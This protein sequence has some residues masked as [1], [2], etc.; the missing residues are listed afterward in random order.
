[1]NFQ[2]EIMRIIS[3]F[4]YN[5]KILLIIIYLFL[6][7]VIVHTQVVEDTLYVF[8]DTVTFLDNQ[9]GLILDWMANFAV[10][11]NIPVE[12][13][14]IIIKKVA[15]VFY[16]LD[17]SSIFNTNFKISTGN[18]P[19]EFILYEQNINIDSAT[20]MFPEWHIYELDSAVQIVN[21][22]SNNSFFI[23]GLIFLRTAASYLT[24][25]AISNQYIFHAYNEN[26][27]EASHEYFPVKV[28]VDKIILGIQEDF[29]KTDDFY[30]YQN[31]P[32]PF[33]PITNIQFSLSS[34]Q[35]VTLRVYDVLGK[36]I[37][38]L[39]HE[40]K[41][42]GTYNIDFNASILTSGL[43]FYQLKADIYSKTKK[44]NVI[45]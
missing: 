35:Y 36:E 6:F 21:D 31:Y 8:P 15:F 11:L 28:I 25:H 30:L 29:T 4:P 26:W 14:N 10:K 3:S 1:M 43:Y 5:K 23:S 19:E 38:T 17:D 45:K 34:R 7:T 37:A 32:N 22:S 27:V 2:S 42:A 24:S 16:N 33:N 44:M 39:L 41:P 40:E 13:K 18:I 9:N 20:S 12:V